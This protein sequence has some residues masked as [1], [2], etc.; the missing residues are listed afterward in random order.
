MDKT[1]RFKLTRLT[2]ATDK[3][4]AEDFK[5]GVADRHTIDRILHLALE[6]HHHSGVQSPDTLVSGQPLL[7]VQRIGGGMPAGAVY[8]YRYTLVDLY[9]HESGG[10]QVGVAQTSTQVTPP[11]GPP[12]LELD[13][14]GLL[15]GG[16]YSYQVTAYTIA[17]SNETTPS[18]AAELSVTP[19]RQVALAMPPLPSG[20]TGFNVYRRGPQDDRYYYVAST[21]STTAVDNSAVPDRNRPAPTVNT[22][23]RNGSVT[24]DLPIDLPVNYGWNIYR[25]SDPSNWSGT[26]L[27]NRHNDD[28]YLDTGIA[29]TAGSPNANP[30]AV[31]SPTKI[32]LTNHAEVE[33]I[34]P[35]G[36]VSA[37]QDVN[38]DF[39]GTL[40]ISDGPWYWLN[41]WDDCIILSTEA[42]LGR[43]SVPASTDVV[44][45][46]EYFLPGGAGWT[47]LW[48]HTI[49]VGDNGVGPGTLNYHATFGEMFRIRVTQAGGG[50]TP[51]DH[52]LTVTLKLLTRHGTALNSGTWI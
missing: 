49:P 19:L 1:T 17:T 43:G 13:V 48:E 41:E 6:G 29:T 15:T 52:D 21:T 11:A 22:T 32:L 27:A 20:A 3:V 12:I 28:S 5:F 14:T 38:F 7:N 26:L 40:F 4:S 34:L 24:V 42:H 37:T 16:R 35:P 36:C 51:T 31:G 33:G 10:S 46:V 18:L 47:Q 2:R 25:T 44:V 39:D 45:D 9:G 50:A 23:N 8:Y 30:G